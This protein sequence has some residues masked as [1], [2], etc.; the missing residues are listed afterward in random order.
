MILLREEFDLYLEFVIFLLSGILWL[1][2]LKISGLVL[3]L[4]INLAFVTFC[5]KQYH[6]D[7]I[8]QSRE[9]SVFSFFSLT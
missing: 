9:N 6:S 7:D 3:W 1:S 8:V 5:L 4:L 2:Y